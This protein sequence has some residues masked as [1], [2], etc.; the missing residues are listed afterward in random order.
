MQKVE[1]ESIRVNKDGQGAVGVSPSQDQSLVS[2]SVGTADKTNEDSSLQF[3]GGLPIKNDSEALVQ[4][5]EDGQS[6][7]EEKGADVEEVQ[8]SNK[9]Q[10]EELA[11]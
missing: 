4:E 9:D 8:T 1:A 5:N 3:K 2:Q 11:S 7:M 6:L 10:M